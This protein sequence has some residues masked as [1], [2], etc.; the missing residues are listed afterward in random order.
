[1]EERSELS[2]SGEPRAL[3]CSPWL[4]ISPSLAR[5]FGVHAWPFQPAST[6]QTDVPPE[7]LETTQAMQEDDV[8]GP[9]M[10]PD[11][12][13]LKRPRGHPDSVEEVHPRG[14]FTRIRKSLKYRAAETTCLQ[15]GGTSDPDSDIHFE[16]SVMA[17]AHETFLELRT[18]QQILASLTRQ[19]Q[20]AELELR[21]EIER[22]R[23]CLIDVWRFH[24]DLYN[25]IR[26]TLG[27]TPADTQQLRLGHLALTE[28]V[29]QFDGIVTKSIVRGGGPQEH[30]I[31]IAEAD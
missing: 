27:K 19:L 7:H 10:R 5:S 12:R 13:S 8:C 20:A 31:H 2:P 22:L 6:V 1:M 17:P 30:D 4:T 23:W 11:P 14:D 26:E 21:D 15:A 28:L 29:S 25:A 16:R 9:S 3:W 24:P 18:T